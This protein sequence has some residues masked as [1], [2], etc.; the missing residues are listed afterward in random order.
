MIPKIIHYI[1]LGNAPF[2]KQIEDCIK[3]WEIHMPDWEIK[4]WN[5]NSIKDIKSIWLSECMKEKKWAFASDYIRMYALYNYGGIYLDTDFKVF[6]SFDN[7]LDNKAFIGREKNIHIKG[8]MKTCVDLTSYCFGAEKGNVFIKD[9]LDYYKNRHFFQSSQKWLPINFRYNMTNL[10]YIMCEIAKL[11]GFKD[12]FLSPQLQQ[13]KALTIFPHKYF[14]D[15]KLSSASY[16]SH[17]SIGSWRDS[18]PEIP[19]YTIKYKIEWR[20]HAFFKS[21]FKRFKFLLI[22]LT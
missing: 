9:C 5:E 8:Y 4:L 13:L 7:I 22:K 3:S 14:G 16:G 18:I 19:R 15:N 17:L 20:I 2:P 12:T 10:S 11:H 21:L 1:W 6:K